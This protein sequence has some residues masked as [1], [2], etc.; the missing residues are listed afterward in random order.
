MPL[1]KKLL[2]VSLLLCNFSFAQAIQKESGY[3]VRTNGDTLFGHITNLEGLLTPSFL[4]FIDSQ[5]SK[6][7]TISPQEIKC[8]YDPKA[9]YFLSRKVM[10]DQSGMEIL[11]LRTSPEPELVEKLIFLHQERL[12]RISLFSYEYSMSRRLFFVSKQQDSI[13]PLIDYYYLSA[14]KESDVAELRSDVKVHVEKYKGQLNF[15]M[16]DQPEMQSRIRGVR[17]DLSS[18]SKLIDVYNNL[19]QKA[20]WEETPLISADRNLFG[21]TAGIGSGQL[22]SRYKGDVD[23]NFKA[24]IPVRLAVFHEYSPERLKGFI[25]FQNQLAMDYYKTS[26]SKA[27]LYEPYMYTDYLTFA[28][29]SLVLT[30]NIKICTWN[31]PVS[32][33]VTLGLTNSYIISSKNTIE[34]VSARNQSVKYL[35][36]AK[37]LVRYHLFYTVGAGV[38]YKRYAA[39]IRYDPGKAYTKVVT[40]DVHHTAAFLLLS[41]YFG[42][43]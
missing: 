7:L 30:N 18:M 26:S 39:E 8:F 6:E 43:H 29:L 1:C 31:R 2:I 5:N 34:R 21:V 40:K 41:Y 38:K 13:V 27:F 19:Y 28:P 24:D 20:S 12:G 15:L 3:L 4:E 42:K 9:G 22:Y 11:S 16:S 32:F 35:E 37:D 10:V 23:Y 33:Y 36:V 14:A 25:K 17:Y